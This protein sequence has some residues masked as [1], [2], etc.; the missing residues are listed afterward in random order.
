MDDGLWAYRT[1]FKTP[2]G[3]FPYKLVFG[4]ACHLSMEL[5]HRVYWVKRK[6]NIDFQVAREKRLLQLN[7]L[8]EFQ[9]E[10][11]ENAKIYKEK[12]KAWHDK[13]I[14]RKE[15]QPGQQVLLFNSMLKFKIASMK[16]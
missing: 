10:A 11:Y 6:L 12:T 4:K 1:T 9:H 7:E 8:D 16:A 15:F 2:I 13:H 3:T 14:M 5:Q